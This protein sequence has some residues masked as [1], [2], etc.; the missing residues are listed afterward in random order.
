MDGLSTAGNTIGAPTL[1]NDQLKVIDLPS[2][3][4]SDDENIPKLAANYSNQTDGTGDSNQYEYYEDENYDKNPNNL[5]KGSDPSNE[6]EEY[7]DNIET[8]M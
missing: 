7:D 4:T 2:N 1:G 5:D 8:P 3:D 6:N